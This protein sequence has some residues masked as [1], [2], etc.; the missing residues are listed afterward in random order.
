MHGGCSGWET[1]FSKRGGIPG[2]AKERNERRMRRLKYAR[3]ECKDRNKCK[4]SVG[5]IRVL[6]TGIRDR[7]DLPTLS[8]ENATAMDNS[9]DMQN[10][11]KCVEF[12]YYVSMQHITV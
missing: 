2:Y 8:K 4:L 10:F 6:K 9:Q 7:L 12:C 11:D 5:A 1:T 3:R